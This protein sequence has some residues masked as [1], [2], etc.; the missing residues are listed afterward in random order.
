[1]SEWVPGSSTISLGP[2]VALKRS[3]LWFGAMNRSRC[4]CTN[5]IGVKQLAIF[6]CGLMALRL[7]CA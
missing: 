6:A 4:P 7:K 3:W 2:L 1:M 5:R